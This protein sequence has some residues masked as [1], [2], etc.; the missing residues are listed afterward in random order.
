MKKF[1][2]SVTKGYVSSWDQYDAVREILQNAIDQEATVEDNQMFVTH[3]GDVLRIGNKN[4]VLPIES[5]LLGATSKEESDETIGKFGEGYKIATLVLTRLGKEVVVYNYGAREVWK[6][7]FVKSRRYKQEVLTF[8]VDT[9]FI[10]KKVPDNNL[11][12]EIHGITKEE[13]EVIKSNTLQ[14]QSYVNDKST[15]KGDVLTSKEHASKIFVNGLYVATNKDLK[16]G[17]NFPPS[18]LSLDRDRRMV[19]DFN[20]KWNSSEIWAALSKDEENINLILELTVSDYID[21]DYVASTRPSMKTADTALHNFKRQYGSN[22]IP[23]TTQAQADSLSNEHKPI[24]VKEK[25]QELIQRSMDY[26]KPARKQYNGLHEA[27]TAW[28]KLHEA[29]IGWDANEELK[30][31]LEE[32]DA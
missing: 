12:F 5:L 30:K 19:S 11:V 15:S 10:W 25:H 8:F 2:L 16:Y 21:A 23:V 20:T 6:P 22:A 28:R 13:Y 4:S 17:Y 3:E 14:L 26:T 7:R 32:Y 18:V 29:S 24:I 1:E 9:E 31:I 27:V